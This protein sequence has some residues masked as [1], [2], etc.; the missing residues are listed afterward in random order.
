[1]TSE[2]AHQ[3]ELERRELL[4]GLG[5]VAIVMTIKEI[6]ELSE[7]KDVPESN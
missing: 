2:E 5:V 1:M 6:Q 3:Q 7:V 4:Q